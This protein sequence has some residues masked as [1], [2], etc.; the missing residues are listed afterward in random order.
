MDTAAQTIANVRL[1]LEDPDGVFFTTSDYVRSYNDALDE[2]SEQTEIRES[3]VYVKRKKWAV[4]TDLRGILPP[5]ALRITA[6][7]N[8]AG[9]KWLD[10]TTV[11]EMDLSV[12]RQWETN[13]GQTRWWFMRG[14]WHLGTYPI[15]GSDDAP[16]RIHYTTR[17]DHITE[18]DSQVTGLSSQPLDL[19]PDFSIAIENYMTY[20]LLAE[21][22]E[23]KKSLDYY[24][25]FQE[26]M[27]S[28][29]NLAENRT[30]RDRTPRMGSRR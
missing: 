3:S 10:P 1:R 23:V 11:R 27:P 26:Q 14:L 9:E 13:V 28:L 5:N 22:K 18:S 12:G 25:K 19:P 4:Y 2:I 8:P 29:K 16:L 15:A 30:R 7:W 21:R 17:L 6:I 20:D 24:G